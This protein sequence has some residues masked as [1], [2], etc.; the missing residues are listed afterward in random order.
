MSRLDGVSLRCANCL[1]KFFW[2]GDSDPTLYNHVD[3][4]W[5][6]NDEEV[7]PFLAALAKQQDNNITRSEYAEIRD[8]ATALL[9][10]EWEHKQRR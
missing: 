6:K 8:L 2:A 10:T 5:R 7:D 3:T 9:E 1:T 4:C